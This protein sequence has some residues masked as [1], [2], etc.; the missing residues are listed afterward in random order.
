MFCDGDI[1][2]GA[3]LFIQDILQTFCTFYSSRGG[4]TDW[5][6]SSATETNYETTEDFP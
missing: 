6:L 1:V 2:K 4:Q 3:G 5:F